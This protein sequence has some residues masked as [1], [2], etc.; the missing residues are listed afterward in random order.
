MRVSRG[1]WLRCR[2]Y[3][4][5]PLGTCPQLPRRRPAEGHLPS[6]QGQGQGQSSAKPVPSYSRT[7]SR[8]FCS[9]PFTVSGIS[10]RSS[11]PITQ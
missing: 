4:R 8:K 3:T 10:E 1:G 11:P 5:A 2:E 6:G 7:R 9:M